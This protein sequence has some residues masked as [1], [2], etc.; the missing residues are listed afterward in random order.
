MQ[1]LKIALRNVV[2]QRKRSLLLGG[3]IA[4]GFFVFTL[5]SGFTGG[6]LKTVQS[7]IAGALGGEIYVAGSEVSE[8]GSEITVIRDTDT[9]ESALDVIAEQIRSYNTRSSA[10]ASLIFGSSQTLQT[11]VGVNFDEETNLLDTLTLVEGSA[12]AFLD[13][14]N[15]LL[16]PVKTLKDLGL[17]VGENVL[18]RTS[19]V[20]AQQNVGDFVVAGT[21]EV[22]EG[23]GVTSGYAHIETLNALLNMQAGQYQTLNIY[24]EDLSGLES[25]TSALLA[26]LERS[27]TVKP[28]EAPGF[29]PDPEAFLGLGGLSSVDEDERWQGTRF[30]ITNLNDA[31]ADLTTLVDVINAIGTL[32]FVVILLI[33]MVG[34]MNAYRMVMLERTVEIGTMRALGLHKSGI[35][36]I[37]VW[38]AVFIAFAGALAGLVAASLTMLGLGYVSFDIPNFSFF[39]DA[40]RL[41]F[42]LSLAGVMGS[43][44]LLCLL[45]VIA[46]YVPA[47]AAANLKPADALRTA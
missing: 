8:A 10:R 38:E 46:V 43:A 32:V 36:K 37:F 22:E 28:R 33:I 13:N 18:V 45:S 3:A 16:L 6:L 40:G 35:R 29:G 47:R 31:A 41:R 27:A 1:I 2:R 39:L 9:L 11:L 5:V 20:N 15:A 25:T 7:N 44:L 12:Q 30:E 26:Q 23:F 34:I 19:T 21:L 4:F 17:E 42:A 14:P 24:V